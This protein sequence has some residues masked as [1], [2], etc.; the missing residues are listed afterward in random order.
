[1]KIADAISQK[2]DLLKEIRNLCT[3]FR[4]NSMIEEGTTALANSYELIDRIFAAA[5]EYKVITQKINET[6]LQEQTSKNRL[7]IDALINQEITK[8]T[9][10]LLSRG[11]LF[12]FQNQERYNKEQ[13][14][15]IRTTSSFIIRQELDKLSNELI[16]FKKE[17]LEANWR[18][19]IE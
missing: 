2:N 19:D 12:F 1:M 16:E 8:T 11:S 6:Y 14:K 18:I 3:R 10:T 7:I 5:N 13:V 9:H 4:L 15:R 17:L